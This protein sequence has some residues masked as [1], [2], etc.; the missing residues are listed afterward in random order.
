M[1]SRIMILLM[2][3]ICCINLESRDSVLCDKGF[4]VRESICAHG[5][6][7]NIKSNLVS[8]N[9]FSS[10]FGKAIGPIL[11][12]QKEASL[13]GKYKLFIVRGK[14]YPKLDFIVVSLNNR[15]L[16]VDVSIVVS[17]K[18][19]TYGDRTWYF[20]LDNDKLA[21]WTPYFKPL[22]VIDLKSIKDT[23]GFSN[24]H[25]S[26]ID[27]TNPHVK[28]PNRMRFDKD[29]VGDGT[30]ELFIS[31]KKVVPDGGASFFRLIK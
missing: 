7:Q 19:V 2:G 12:I 1:I 28:I 26:E 20:L 5:L 23:D 16:F 21:Y 8:K 22:N 9:I 27:F 25:V 30:Y 6:K 18:E 17:E 24:E 4:V 14:K 13:D 29:P 31:G 15:P 10:P 11:K 3:F